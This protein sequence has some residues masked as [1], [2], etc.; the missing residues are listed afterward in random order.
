MREIKF[1]AWETNRKVMVNDIKI[2]PKYGW[3]VLA[4]NDTIEG[5]SDNWLLMQYTGLKD[6]NGKEIYEGDIVSG[7]FGT[8][9]TEVFYEN[10]GFFIMLQLSGIHPPSEQMLCN[11]ISE[12]G[13]IG[14]KFENPELLK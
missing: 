4:D 12:I 1:R 2:F 3:L 14:N 5:C 13:I 6:K 7:F 8:Q 11:H 9:K 10:G